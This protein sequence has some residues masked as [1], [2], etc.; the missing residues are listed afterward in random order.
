VDN[1]IKAV[2][3]GMNGVVFKDDVQAADVYACKRYD[4]V[5]GVQVT[6]TEILPEVL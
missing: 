3:D 2:F 5:P 4:E 6:V 1:V